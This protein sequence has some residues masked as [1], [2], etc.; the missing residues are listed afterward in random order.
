[1]DNPFSQSPV[2]SEAT[3]SFVGHRWGL[4][5]VLLPG[6]LLILVTLGIYRFWQVTA[7]R[8][9]Y[10]NHTSIDGDAL[11]YSGTAS[12]LL[13]GFLIALAFFLPLYVLFF[14]LST[15][16]VEFVIY[17]YLGAAVF[18]Y[19]LAGYASYR[20]RR[21]RLSRT[22]W[23]GIR[24][25]QSGNAWSYALRRFLWSILVIVTLGLAYPFMSA[26]LWRY[27]YDHTWYGDRQFSFKGSWRTVAAPFYI[28]YFIMVALIV[29]AAFVVSASGGN[30]DATAGVIVLLS[31]PLLLVAGLMF[32]HLK[33]R[34]TSRFLSSVKA[35]KAGLQVRVK[36]RS[37]VWM[38]LFYALLFALVSGLFFAIIMVFF[39]GLMEPLFQDEG[40]DVSQIAQLGW[41]NVAG[42]GLIYLGLLAA[43]GALAETV[44]GLGYWRMVVR[45][46]RIT[47]PDDLRSVR[48]QGD[49]SP[50]TG[51]GIADALNVGAY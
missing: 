47:N 39:T 48:A 8:H 17:G 49:E 21:F 14:Y 26:S 29:G 13:I 5:G 20:A 7:K 16:S 51:E 12:Q 43:Y 41:V 50:I 22:F 2:Q 40:L 6:Y 28:D 25:G 42:L 18:L 4:F 31:M 10:W 35:G 24:F 36:A 9:Y 33:S 38:Y 46:A 11:E 32:V 3:A 27:R 15:Q 1:M 30:S 44:L 45:G 37:F 19:F 23:R 34:F